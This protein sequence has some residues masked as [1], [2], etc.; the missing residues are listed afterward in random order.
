VDEKQN[1]SRVIKNS[2]WLI[3]EIKKYKFPKWLDAQH[4]VNFLNMYTCYGRDHKDYFKAYNQR[5]KTGTTPKNGETAT[6][7]SFIT[8]DGN[9]T[10]EYFYKWN[11][12]GYIYDGKKVH[13][14]GLPL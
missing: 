14:V 3:S 2:K 8:A 5:L 7:E 1:K 13:T 10:G 4:I 12:I 9:V 6:L 11:N